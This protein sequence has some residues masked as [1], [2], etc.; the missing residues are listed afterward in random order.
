[1]IS[2]EDL[3]RGDRAA[4]AEQDRRKRELRETG[5]V[6]LARGRLVTCRGCGASVFDPGGLDACP[7]CKAS[8]GGGA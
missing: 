3:A 5:A 6:T 4:L 8:I 2:P 7:S 1:M